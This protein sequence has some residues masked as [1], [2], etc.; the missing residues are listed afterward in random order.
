MPAPPRISI[1]IGDYMKNTPPFS[2]VTWEHHGIYIAL[3]FAAWNTPGCRLPKDTAWIAGRIGCTPSTFDTKVLPV[4]QEYFSLRRNF[5][6]QKRL[7]REFEYVT[8]TGQRQ[9][10]RAVLKW[11]DD[12]GHAH[13]QI[14]SA[15][16]SIARKLGTHSPEEWVFL[17]SLFGGLC[18]I[19]GK[20]C[21]KLVKDHIRPI[22]QGGS[23]AIENLQPACQRCNSQKGADD[24]DHRASKNALWMEQFA[25]AFSR[26]LLK[27]ND[28]NACLSGDPSNACPPIPTPIKKQQHKKSDSGVGRNKNGSSR[29]TIKD[30]QERLR[31]FQAKLLPHLGTQGRAIL[32]AI[33]DPSHPDH[34]DAVKM[35]KSAAARWMGKRW[36]TQLLQSS[37]GA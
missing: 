18:V 15:R 17:K 9:K 34:A 8:A 27:D 7:T 16:L 29:V 4:L 20:P 10:G 33:N 5:W 21:A 26:K 22:F 35:G 1:H 13:S 36:P 30:P 11:S 37:E 31:R 3:L 14:R 12:E 2:A 24:T 23:D 32:A 28:G 19:C 25:E 6:Y